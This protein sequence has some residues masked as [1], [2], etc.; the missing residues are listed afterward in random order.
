[1]CLQG[2]SPLQQASRVDFQTNLVDDFLVKVDRTSML[3]SLEVRTP[4][5]DHRLIELAFGGLADR[6]RATVRE[7]KILPRLLAQRLL[8]PQL[9]LSRKQGFS[10]PLN[11]WFRGDWGRFIEEVLIKADPHL[12]N[13]RMI[14]NL[15]AGQRHGYA[16]TNRLFLLTMF[17]L[18]RQTYKVAVG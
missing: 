16:N 6:L 1:L 9:D 15:I 7:R 12:F 14:Q 10:L 4:W 17:E 18:W 13:Q 2:H 3:T 11:A 5:L 8:P